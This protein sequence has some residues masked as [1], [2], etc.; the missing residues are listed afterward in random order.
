MK[1]TRKER[2]LVG[3]DEQVLHDRLRVGWAT[4]AASMLLLATIL[5][6]VPAPA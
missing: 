3:R 5:L 2:R 4:V 1:P 6:A